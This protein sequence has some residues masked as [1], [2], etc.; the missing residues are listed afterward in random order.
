MMA[1]ARFLSLVIVLCSLVEAPAWAQKPQAGPSAK[2]EVR[3]IARE[4]IEGVT[5]PTDDDPEDIGY[6]HIKPALVVTAGD[7]EK[8]TFSKADWGKKAVKVH[9]V[10]TIHLTAK[11]KKKLAATV[12]A[13]P[14]AGLYGPN[15][16]E[17]HILTFVV[18]GE[19]NGAM[20]YE[21]DES[22]ENVPPQCLASNFTPTITL[23]ELSQ[24]QQVVKALTKPAGAEGAASR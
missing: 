11:A 1:W 12:K 2:I 18:D 6:V 21:I 17:F 15:D 13:T 24:V 8:V 9:Y 3:C 7:V 14:T 20:R 23:Q 4:P 16:K 22:R 5:D 10:V 19:R